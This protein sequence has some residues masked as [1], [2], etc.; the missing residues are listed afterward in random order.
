MKALLTFLLALTIS[1]STFA[2]EPEH[3]ASD[4]HFNK[5]KERHFQVATPGSVKEALAVYDQYTASIAKLLSKK[6]YAAAHEQS[7][8][9]MAAGD[10]LN[11]QI[12]DRRLAKTV[13]AIAEYSFEV[14]EGSEN[15]DGKLAETNLGL[16]NKELKKLKNKLKA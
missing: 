2:A 4:A 7:Y 1:V 16:L 12:T 3:K 9:L 6:D 5:E 13:S 14:H 11:E 8:H 10:A 15:G